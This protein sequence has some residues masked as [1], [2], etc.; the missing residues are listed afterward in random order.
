MNVATIALASGGVALA[1]MFG[2]VFE[3]RR[4]RRAGAPRNSVKRAHVAIALFG[5]AAV[6]ATFVWAS[7]VPESSGPNKGSVFVELLVQLSG[8][9]IFTAFTIWFV[10]WQIRRVRRMTEERGEPILTRRAE[11]EL[12]VD[13]SL[14]LQWAAFAIRNIGAHNVEVDPDDGRISAS[15]PMHWDEVPFCVSADID[16]IGGSKSLVHLTAWPKNSEMASSDLGAVQYFIDQLSK[17]IIR[18][19]EDPPDRETPANVMRHV[20]TE[21][22]G[23]LEVEPSIRAQATTGIEALDAG[24]LREAEALTNQIIEAIRFTYGPGDPARRVAQINLDRKIRELGGIT[25]T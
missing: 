12:G 21:V 23:M 5:L 4:L 25:D 8:P 17:D 11:V 19:S 16:D 13:P 9:V 2:A 10:W 18:I 20:L 6:V 7:A 15:T 24:R 1:A 3:L 14:A 22:A